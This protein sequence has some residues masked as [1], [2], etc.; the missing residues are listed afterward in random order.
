MAVSTYAL[1]SELLCGCALSADPSDR[2]IYVAEVY[3]LLIDQHLLVS[4]ARELVADHAL[5]YR[6]ARYSYTHP[7]GF[8][9]YMLAA[10]DEPGYRLRLHVWDIPDG[11]CMR[12][13]LH[14][15]PRDF[16][17][18]VV[19]GGLTDVRYIEVS[20]SA[21]H[22]E[23]FL[24]YRSKERNDSERYEIHYCGDQ[25][26][27][28]TDKSEIKPG[29]TYGLLHQ[30]IHTTIPNPGATTVT[31]FIQGPQCREYAYVYDRTS[32]DIQ[33]HE[34]PRAYTLT[35]YVNQLSS[36]QLY[37]YWVYDWISFAV[38]P[39]AIRITRMGFSL[40]SLVL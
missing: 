29:E 32:I 7:N 16:W 26:L 35:E 15:H 39:K 24:K 28:E 12:G 34:R 20:A 8:H 10:S 40:P 4:L 33:Q 27:R 18:R 25:C 36:A 6:M 11:E 31:L 19:I 14:D 30:V 22:A 1:I 5:A 9:K 2:L 23:T 3:E 21:P 13:N 37:F 38:V 17:S